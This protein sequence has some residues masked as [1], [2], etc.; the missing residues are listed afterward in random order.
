MIFP[1][2]AHTHTT[3]CDGLSTIEEMYK[4]AIENGF[5]SLGFSSH[6]DQGFDAEY[7]MA[8]GKQAQYFH[9]LHNLQKQADITIYAGLELDLKANAD[10]IKE[11]KQRADYLIGSYHYVTTDPT[12]PCVAY[13]GNPHQLKAYVQEFY[14]GDG[15][16]MAEQYYI[17]FSKALVQYKP[18]IIGH[19]DLVKKYAEA[20]SLFSTED[21]AYQRIASEALERS[22]ASGAILE[23]NT[24]AMAR[25]TLQTPYPTDILLTQWLDMGG[26]VTITS[27]CHNANYLAFAFPQMIE[28]LRKLGYKEVY[29]LGVNTMWDSLSLR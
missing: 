4:A 8:N 26:K 16:A 6:A 18:D 29:Y 19:F 25:G 13:D 11:A 17:D 21:K 7:S 20:F 3:Y 12:G 14:H 2:N 9:A 5:I 24:G 15:L 27:D 10:K 23:I 1:S 28:K 22:F